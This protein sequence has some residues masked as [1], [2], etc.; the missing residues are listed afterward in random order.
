[1]RGTGSRNVPL[2]ITRY[3]G[4]KDVGVCYQLTAEM[5]EGT[6]GYVQLTPNELMC[7]LSVVRNDIQELV[8]NNTECKHERGSMVTDNGHEWF[9]YKHCNKKYERY[10]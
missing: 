2:T 4:G 9:V 8:S 3:Y 1:M 7:I 5:E 6:T 10:F